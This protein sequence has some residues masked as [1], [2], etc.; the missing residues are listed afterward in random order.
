MLERGEY[1]K[2]ILMSGDNTVELELPFKIDEY[3]TSIGVIEDS[4]LQLVVQL[5]DK[6]ARGEYYL[7]I[8]DDVTG[9]LPTL[10]VAGIAKKISKT[11][12][13]AFPNVRFIWAS[14]HMQNEEVEMQIDM[15]LS[16]MPSAR[17]KEALFVTDYIGS[18]ETTSR[19]INALNAKG[20]NVD[21]AT[22]GTGHVEEYY[23]SKGLFPKN[24]R[25]FAGHQVVPASGVRDL[26][27]FTGL[28]P[29]PH[30][31]EIK[32]TRWKPELAMVSVGRRDVNRMIERVTS[33]LDTY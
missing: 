16:K 1:A 13:V 19:T 18:G 5:R 32:A 11:A 31:K 3:E 14:R 17:D 26:Q 22:L 23:R 30:F 20:I 6:F 12:G 8:G 24:T 7:I 10:V 21:I 9:R 29:K 25:L 28:H 27:E 15:M 33:R 2:I 4:I